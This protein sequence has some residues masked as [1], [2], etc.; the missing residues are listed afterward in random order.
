VPSRPSRCLRSKVPGSGVARRRLPQPEELL[1]VRGH[2]QPPTPLAAAVGEHFRASGGLHAGPKAVRALAARVVRL[3]SAFHWLELVPSLTG[4]GSN[5]ARHRSSRTSPR[6]GRFLYLKA[7]PSARRNDLEPARD[8]AARPG[9]HPPP[10]RL[11]GTESVHRSRS[12]RWFRSHP[13]YVP[14]IVTYIAADAPIL[15][16]LQKL[17][18][19]STTALGWEIG[20]FLDWISFS[21][22]RSPRHSGSGGARNGPLL[23]FCSSSLF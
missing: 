11:A 15:V 8:P 6:R 5:H 3:V 4:A 2:G 16:S 21:G 20:A 12:T 23:S 14:E 10:V 19:S 7:A 18:V 1:L 17:D 22:L 13:R 9:A